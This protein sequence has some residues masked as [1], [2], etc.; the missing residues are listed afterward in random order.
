MFLIKF[1]GVIGIFLSTFELR[2]MAGLGE[3]FRREW[4]IINSLLVTRRALL[5]VKLGVSTS[6][7]AYH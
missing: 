1:R 7:C 5:Y 4:S 2:L 6:I 3:L